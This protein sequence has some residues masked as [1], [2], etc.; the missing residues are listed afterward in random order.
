MVNPNEHNVLGGLRLNAPVKETNGGRTGTIVEARGEGMWGV[1]FDG[2]TEIETQEAKQLKINIK[3]FDE[4][5]SSWSPRFSSGLPNI[6]FIPRK[7]QPLGTELRPVNPE[8]G[9]SGTPPADG[10]D[11]GSSSTGGGGSCTN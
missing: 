5:F 11:T 9:G 6:T 3:A 4:S 2:S 8:E 1:K 7:P 10:P